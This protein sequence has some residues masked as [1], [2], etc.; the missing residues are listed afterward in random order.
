M[1]KIASFSLGEIKAQLARS[2]A[3]TSANIS[4]SKIDYSDIPA[5]TDEQLSRF[6]KA[7]RG[8]P[9]LG[10]SKRRLISIKLEPSLIEDLKEEAHR[11]GTKYQSLIH[12]ILESHFHRKKP[13]A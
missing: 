7:R 10:Q 13:A 5:L 12:E 8:R 3:K 11:R 6:K 4:D 1:Q 2:L 9:L